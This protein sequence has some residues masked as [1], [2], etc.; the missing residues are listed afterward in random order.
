MTRT[1]MLREKRRWPMRASD[2]DIFSGG[3]AKEGDEDSSFFRYGDPEKQKQKNF[4]APRSAANGLG[5]PSGDEGDDEGNKGDNYNSTNEE[6][7]AN[8]PG[9]VFALGGITVP[10]TLLTE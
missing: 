2:K 7:V 3:E 6:D 8:S 5:L 10:A 1:W 9:L 4:Q